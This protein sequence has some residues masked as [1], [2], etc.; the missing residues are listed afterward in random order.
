M[1]YPYLI[2]Q[3]QTFGIKIR[4]FKNELLAGELE[5]TVGKAFVKFRKVS[6]A[7]TIRLY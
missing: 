4:K 7:Y 2:Y 5:L 3:L 6:D 1:T